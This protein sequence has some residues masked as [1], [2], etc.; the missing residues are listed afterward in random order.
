LGARV[1]FGEARGQVRSG[2]APQVMAA[3]RNTVIA[4][5]RHLGATNVATARRT[6]AGHPD[7]AVALVTAPGE[8]MQ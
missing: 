6:H 2:A 7:R 3:L 8:T 4:F 5:L 1:T